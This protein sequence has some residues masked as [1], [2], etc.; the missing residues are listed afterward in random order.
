MFPFVEGVVLPFLMIL[1]I[2]GIV[3]FYSLFFKKK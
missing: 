1:A 3:Y 2:L